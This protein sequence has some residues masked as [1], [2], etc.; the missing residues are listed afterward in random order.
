MNQTNKAPSQIND[1][2][3]DEVKSKTSFSFDFVL[4]LYRI[5]K[6]WYLFAIAII[7]SLILAN[8]ENRKETGNFG[9]K[10]LLMIE[11]RGEGSPVAAAVPGSAVLQNIYNQQ[12]ALQSRG[13]IE[14]TVDNLPR[15]MWI[16]YYRKTRFKRYVMYGVNPVEVISL[17]L[18]PEAYYYSYNIAYVDDE[19]CQIFYEGNEQLAPYSIV[20]PY[21]KII[22]NGQFKIILKKTKDY[23]PEF[24]TFSFVFLSKDRMIA[25]FNRRISCRL[26]DENATALD[27]RI[28]GY[29]KDYWSREMDFMNAF[30]D[31]FKNYSLSLKNT[32]ASLTIEFI[33]KQLK[34]INDSLESSRIALD[35]F[36][37]QTGIYEI[38][39]P[40]LREEIKSADKKIEELRLKERAILVVADKLST[41]IKDN[42]E[43]ID[44]KMFGLEEEG[45]SKH[46][47]AYNIALKNAKYIGVK[48]PTFDK[49]MTALN[50][51]RRLILTE[52]QQIMLK[53]EKE[54]ERMRFEYADIESEI[55]HLPPIER[56][57]LKYQRE[58]QMNEIYQRF[59]TQRKYEAQ[60]QK[61]SNTPDNSILEEPSIDYLSTGQTGK[62]Y[63][64]YLIWGML[65]PLVFV[66]LRE[67]VL[68]FTI[69]TKEECERLS[70]YP[71]IG[72][73]ENVASKLSKGMVLVKN[74]PKSSFAESFRN[75]RIRIEY[76]AKKENHI[77]TLITSTEPADGKTFVATNIA[78]AY[79]LLGKK[80]II[81]DL[82][83]RRPSVAKT[84]QLPTNKG[85]SNY[86]IGQV[87]LEEIITSPPNYG[88]D[89]I[90][91]GTLP[92][93]PSELIRT[94]KTRELIKHL[95]SI[96]DYVIIDCSPVGLVS[97]AYIL[98]KI[99][100]TSIFVVRR[101]KTNKSFFK[102]VISQV[103]M[104][105][106][107]NVSLVFNDVKGREGYY[108]T[109]RYYGDRTYYLKKKSSYYH[110]D[111]FE[112]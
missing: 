61:A 45:L 30:L 35:Q 47:E 9:I 6:Y 48:S 93:N 90:T 15:S 91:A 94:E 108:G 57:L 16:D 55:A 85:I 88:F 64:N 2:Y 20:V 73:I 68:N 42:T 99:V 87:T 14:Q 41:S 103:R 74:Y 34:I 49:V 65:I 10:A 22:D 3:F 52:V 69:A 1:P 79:Q 71:V 89:V 11:A 7:T 56:E 105:G 58:Y 24:D 70:G 43:M 29:N 77:T 110:D 84:L 106:I 75:M 12:I 82:D 96:Y 32:Q 81:V 50:Q 19:H 23:K 83:L 33:D 18:K 101:A 109:S 104:D 95:Q 98:G 76:M 66:I 5:L 78:S 36:Q 59:L 4:W 86:L 39:T 25:T 92:P 13:L 31:E 67:E 80:V 37:K 53:Y 62:N 8:I 97:D 51:Q 112:D 21:N 44:P 28:E 27:V 100:D 54:K 111:Y 40:T 102:S 46:V 63:M 38:A 107:E 72:T 17:D 26:V 60:I